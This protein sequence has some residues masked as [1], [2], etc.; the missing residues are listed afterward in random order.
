MYDKR[1]VDKQFQVGDLAYLKLQSYRQSSVEHRIIHKLSPRFFGPYRVLAK[2][3]VVAYLL[4]LPLGS[5]VHLVFHV[6]L[7]K[8]R[9]G[10]QD[11]VANTSYTIVGALFSTRTCRSARKTRGGREGRAR[12]DGRV[13]LKKRQLG[14]LRTLCNAILHIL[15]FLEDKEFFEGEGIVRKLIRL[16][17]V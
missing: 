6:S 13:A 1:H 10:D 2:I 14:R 11:I 17:V 15:P 16:E 12:Y 7:L 5:R 4:G 3:G 8:K 9:V